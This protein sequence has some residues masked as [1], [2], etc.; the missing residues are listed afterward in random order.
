[1]G[2]VTRQEKQ[3]RDDVRLAEMLAGAFIVFLLV[4]T[5]ALIVFLGFNPLGIQ[6]WM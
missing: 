4:L 5:L 3:R 1:V 2:I 6:A